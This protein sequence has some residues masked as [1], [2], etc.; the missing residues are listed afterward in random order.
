MDAYTARKALNVGLLIVMAVAAVGFFIGTRQ[1]VEVTGYTWFVEP[2]KKPEREYPPALSYS[3]RMESPQR[4]NPGLHSN[5]D[6]LS[7]QPIPE[8]EGDATD[9]ALR[10]AARLVRAEGRAYE[11]APPTVPHPIDHSGD[12][13]CL[14]C[15][16][17]GMRIAGRRAPA[18]SHSTYTNCT[19][20]HVERE[21]NLPFEELNPDA[22]PLDSSFEGF[23]PAREGERVWDGA[24][25]QMPHTTRMRENCASCHGP[26]GP[27]GLRTTH[28]ER[29]SCTQCHAPK[30][31]FNQFPTSETDEFW[32]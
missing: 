3:E 19:Q 15:H 14:V 21:A 10:E 30:A 32:R 11:G 29:Q 9:P 16:Q 31:D 17:S 18:M 20:C 28:P 23:R 7:A 25:P 22:I 12:A 27:E 6:V 8:G 1:G 5:F 13:A 26:H 4:M 2:E 24:P